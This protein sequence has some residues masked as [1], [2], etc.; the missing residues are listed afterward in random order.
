VAALVDA[1]RLRATAAQNYGAINAGNLRRAHAAI[2]AGQVMGKIVLA[3][4]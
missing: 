2:E 1:G 4:F 3:G